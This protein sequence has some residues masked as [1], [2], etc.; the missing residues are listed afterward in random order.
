[1]SADPGAPGPEPKRPELV[2]TVAALRA[3]VDALQST[4]AAQAA[5]IKDLQ[6]AVS[7]AVR[8]GPLGPA[9]TG[10]HPFD[11]AAAGDPRPDFIA[12]Q[13][14]A[15]A[16]HGQVLAGHSEWLASHTEWLKN[17]ERWVTSCV[18]TLSGLGAQPMGGGELDPAG[19][20][21]PTGALRTRLEIATVSDWIANVAEVP[22]DLLITVVVAT[23]DRPA[24]LQRAVA[25]VLASSYP[26]FEVL[27][28]DDNDVEK[29]PGSTA[30]ALAG[31]DD[32][33]LR[34]VRTLARRGAAGAFNAGLA[35][36][37]GDVITALDDDN[38]MHRDWLR[39]VAWAFTTFPEVE[40]L[41]GARVVEDPGARDAVRSG[42]L[43]AIEFGRYERRRHERANYIDRNTLAFRARHRDVRYD[44]DIPAAIDWDHSMRLFDRT[45]PLALPVIACYY[46]TVVTGRV[47]DGARAREGVRTVRRRIFRRRP[48]RIL[49]H[50][51][52]YPVISETYIGEDI[53]ALADCG[54]RVMVTADAAAVSRQPGV[55]PPETDVEGVIGDF[56]PDVVLMHWSTHATGSLPLMARLRQPFACR[57][58][59]FD[60]DPALVAPLLR[61]P[62]CVA[63]FA[64]ETDLGRLPPGVHGLKPVIGPDVTIPAGQDRRPLVVSVSAGL[65]KKNFPLLIEAMAELTDMERVIVMARSNGL[66]SVPEE[67]TALAASVD[68]AI[69]VRVNV[70]RSEALAL[71]GSAQTL[72][73]TVRPGEPIGLPMSIIEAMACGTMVVAP[74]APPTRHLLG[75]DLIPYS[76]ATDIVDG[77]R[78]VSAAGAA[79]EP[80]RDRLRARCE[81]YRSAE[82]R[83]RL[84]DTLMSSLEVWVDERT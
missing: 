2:E 11:L 30:D 5:W 42:A 80:A 75:P 38:L 67:V 29:G 56:S 69:S 63:V 9:S 15:V 48:P 28:V 14:D 22:D 8:P 41:Y 51:A 55:E 27:V 65:P 83:R 84:F 46:R 34:I 21:D 53:A 13:A 39:S 45:T 3:E 82:E 62:L 37:R 40:A 35:A 72:I 68:P 1:M 36:A 70:P 66:E 77:V 7:A 16:A 71:I 58:H 79:L 23:H 31:I 61:H 19:T 33:R 60:A 54:A 50:T 17:L 81:P 52:M 24:L 59:S 57:V 76:T 26:K 18:K 25:S 74:D 64:H 12:A 73:Y 47:T 78:S 20:L 6:H 10:I 49:V 4:V 44:E 32:P 43:P